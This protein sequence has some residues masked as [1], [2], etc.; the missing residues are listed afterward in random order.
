MNNSKKLSYLILGGLGLVGVVWLAVIIA[1]GIRRGIP[2]LIK[3]FSRA[4]DNPFDFKFVAATIPTIAVMALIW[5]I[6]VYIMYINNK[7]FRRGEE[8]GSAK[9][10]GIAAAKSKFMDRRTTHKNENIIFSRNLALATGRGKSFMHRRNHHVLVNGG[11]GLGKT[12]YI[13]E[14]NLLQAND[15]YMFLDPAGEILR[16]CGGFLEHKGY[17]IKVFNLFELERSTRYNSFVYIQTDDD[18]IRMVNMFFKATD[19]K[20]ESSADPFWD[21]AGKMLMGALCFYLHYFAP[22]EDRNLPTVQYLVTQMVSLGDGKEPTVIDQLFQNLERRFPNHIASKAYN[23]YVAGAKETV[24][25]IQITLQARLFK[26]IQPEIA[27]LCYTTEDE[28]GLY[29]IPE[30]KT[31][32]FL[33]VPTQDDSKNFFV[34]L[35]YQQLFDIL[36]GY[37]MRNKRLKVPINFIMDEFANTKVPDG[38]DQLL[39]TVRKFGIRIMIILQNLSQLNVDFKDT[40]DSIIANCDTMIYLGGNDAATQKSISERIGKQTIK[41]ESVSQSKGRNGSYSKSIQLTARDLMTPDEVGALPDDE[42]L[43]MIRG[44]HPLR[45]K[46]YDLKSHPNYKYTAFEDAEGTPYIVP[47][48]TEIEMAKASEYMD[49]VKIRD[50]LSANEIKLLPQLPVD[51]VDGEMIFEIHGPDEE[52]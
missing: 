19:K 20:G 31:A 2:G 45:D 4:A 6:A 8:H 52:M 27:D 43:I 5:L 40:K 7:D 23:G 10:G 49:G 48:R 50:D 15:S 22:E 26:F 29:K 39:A 35:L 37:G 11:S 1:P 34:S 36:I 41:V 24:S 42:M 25:S 9:W 38:F 14:P 46:K 21:N 13:V 51:A 30:K 47:T 12:R 28:L 3:A 33:I 17:D 32:L 44:C 18:V 16:D